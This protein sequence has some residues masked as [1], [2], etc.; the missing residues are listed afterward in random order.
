MSELVSPHVAQG[1]IHTAY[2]MVSQP[3]LQLWA[4]GLFLSVV[5]CYR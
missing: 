2:V 5:D 1:G 3:T 4:A